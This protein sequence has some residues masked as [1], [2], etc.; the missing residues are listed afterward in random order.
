M[1]NED[2]TNNPYNIC[3]WKP[4]S[5][6]K[7]CPIAGILKCRF[8]KKDFIQFIALYLFFAIPAFTGM[9][10]GGYG[11]Y[12]LGYVGFMIFFFFVWESRILCS[13]CPY[14]AENGRI[15]HCIANYGVVKLWKYHPEPMSKLE[16]LQLIIGFTIFLSYPFVFLILGRQYLLTLLTLLGVIIFFGVLHKYTCSRCINFSCPFN[17]VPKRIIDE[18]LKRNPVIKKVWEVHGWQTNDTLS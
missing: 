13:H 16:K 3:T 18:Y 14:Y 11:W 17:T 6:C 12:I 5:E 7:D 15:L 8:N 4:V 10:L 1:I 2:T 9:I